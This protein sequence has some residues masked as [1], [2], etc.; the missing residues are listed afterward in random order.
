[1]DRRFIKGKVIAPYDISRLVKGYI[2]E[3]TN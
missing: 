2:D 1:M 3:H